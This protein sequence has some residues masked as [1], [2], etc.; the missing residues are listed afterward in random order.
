MPFTRNG[1]CELYYEAFGSPSDPTLL[2]ING[3][4]SQCINYAEAWCEKFVA[5]GFHV[6]RFDNR[7][8]GLSTHF[9]DAPVGAQGEAYL[10]SDMADDAI[11]VLDANGVEQAH[12]MGLSMGGMI[13]QTLAIEHPDRLLSM[14]SVMSDTSEP[15][16]RSVVAGGVGPPDPTAG[17]EPRRVRHAAMWPGC[18]SG[19]ARSTPTTI[20]GGPM[21]NG[22]STGASIRP[23]RD[24][25]SS[26]SRRHRREPNC[27]ARS[28]CPC[29]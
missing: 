28:T 12:V 26:R 29:S 10:L 11:A 2:L 3:L 25:S 13:A 6:I 14:T 4:G 21:P 22:P 16:R 24:V 5:R 27:S 18:A 20:A 8:V 19:G 15:D 7:D 17:D 1:D 23:A 9:T